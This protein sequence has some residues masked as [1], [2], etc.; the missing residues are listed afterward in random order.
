MNLRTDSHQEE[1]E[2][3]IERLASQSSSIHFYNHPCSIELNLTKDG[4]AATKAR[5]RFNLSEVKTFE[6]NGETIQELRT[7]DQVITKILQPYAALLSGDFMESPISE[8]CISLEQIC[9]K[10][11]VKG[12]TV[13]PI[14]IDSFG[15]EIYSMLKVLDT[16]QAL[17][18]TYGVK[19]ATIAQGKA[20]S[21]GAFMLMFGDIGYRYAT[22]RTT[23]MVHDLSTEIAGRMSEIQ[24]GYEEAR[25]LSESVMSSLS[26]Y[27][28]QGE[29]STTLIDLVHQTKYTDVYLGAE[30]AK[31]ARIIDHV[32]MPKFVFEL[33]IKERIDHVQQTGMLSKTEP[34]GTKRLAV[35]PRK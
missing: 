34:R 23:I 5:R 30:E 16:M 25:R 2:E 14:Y 31:E 20:M 8:F 13:I 10:A 18:E 28:T 26:Q 15:G 29:S 27:I 12:Q 4:E 7:E 1:Q 9:F 21:A 35:K 33:S 3:I 32:G 24:T 19:F 17:R 11:S 6:K 22:P